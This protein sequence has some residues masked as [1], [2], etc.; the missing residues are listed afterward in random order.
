MWVGV[1]SQFP[2]GC[3][4]NMPEADFR[5]LGQSV[6]GPEPSV[7]FQFPVLSLMTKVKDK[8]ACLKMF[9]VPLQASLQQASACDKSS[10]LKDK[11]PL[12][13]T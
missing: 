9:G 2:F 13:A 11:S 5:H 7:F 1:L 3:Y 6:P 8:A 10:Q 4:A 12:L